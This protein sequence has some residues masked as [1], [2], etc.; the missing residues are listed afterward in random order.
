VLGSGWW[1][2]GAPEFERNVGGHASWK[3]RIHAVAGAVEA[4]K[5]PQG[6]RLAEVFNSLPPNAEIPFLSANAQVSCQAREATADKTEE[7]LAVVCD[8]AARIARAVLD[9]A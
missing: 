3:K 5:N 7:R 6:Q 2:E 9:A 8:S 1:G 4:Y